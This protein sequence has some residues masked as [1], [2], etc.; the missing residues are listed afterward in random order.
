MIWTL[1]R[2]KNKTCQRVEELLVSQRPSISSAQLCLRMVCCSWVTFYKEVG[3]RICT[4]AT[5]KPF[6]PQNIPKA[7]FFH[8]KNRTCQ[9]DHVIVVIGPFQRLSRV[10]FWHEGCAEHWIATFHVT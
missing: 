2:M 8:K 6:I 10:L 7:L 3:G 9:I 1:S 5:V 4:P